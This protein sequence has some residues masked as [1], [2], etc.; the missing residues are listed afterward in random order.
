MISGVLSIFCFITIAG[1]PFGVQLCKLAK[2]AFL[3]FGC[4]VIDDEIILSPIDG[5]DS[6]QTN[7]IPSPPNVSSPKT[8]NQ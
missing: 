4:E 7:Y 6:I 8:S 1:M 2:L 5:K 3:P